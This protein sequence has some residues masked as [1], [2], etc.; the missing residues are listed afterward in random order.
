MYADDVHPLRSKFT[1]ASGAGAPHRDTG[2]YGHADRRRRYPGGFQCECTD[3]HYS[4][5]GFYHSFI[6]AYQEAEMTACGF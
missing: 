5:A 1:E 2:G 3:G 4:F 6:P